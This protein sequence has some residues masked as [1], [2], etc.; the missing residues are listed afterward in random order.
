MP[1]FGGLLAPHWRDDARGTLVG[2]SQ[3]SSRAHIVRAVLEGIAFQV[4]DVLTAV[5]EDTSAPVAVLRVDGG[6]TKNDLLMQMQV[7]SSKDTLCACTHGPA[8]A[9]A[10]SVLCVTASGAFCA[11]RVCVLHG[12]HDRS[13]W[14][15]AWPDRN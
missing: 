2:L 7:R 6:A 9:S 4:Q 3:F 8:S 14:R 1:A 11:V 13:V 15:R 5:A 10:T 12:K